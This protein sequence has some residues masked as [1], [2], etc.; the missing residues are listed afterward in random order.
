MVATAGESRRWWRQ[1][2]WIAVI[3]TAGMLGMIGLATGC[4]GDD[5]GD[6]DA[7]AT[8][9]TSADTAVTSAQTAT[10]ANGVV[11][12]Q[13]TVQ[14]QDPR[15]D[16]YPPA[17]TGPGVP[18]LVFEP[19]ILEMGNMAPGEVFNGV[20]KVR[21]P[22]GQPLRILQ[23]RASCNCTAADLAN[24]VINPGGAADLP[25][26]FDSAGKLGPTAV[27]V[28][29]SV[30]GYTELAQ[31]RVTG[32]VSLAVAAE[33]AYVVTGPRNAAGGF[34]TVLTGEVTV[35]SI[36]NMPFRVLSADMQPPVFTDGFDP[37]SDTPRSSYRLKW[38][39]SSYNTQTCMNA[40]GR[41]MPARWIVETDHPQCGVIDLQVRH[42]C[43]RQR[44]N[45]INQKWRLGDGRLLV[46]RMTPGESREVTIPIRFFPRQPKMIDIVNVV[47]NTDQFA[48][49]F[50]STE[51][52]GD[53]MKA[54]FR[55]TPKPGH[56]GVFSGEVRVDSFDDQARLLV[57]GVVHE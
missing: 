40:Q 20:I 48:I 38:D 18:P 33:P 51:G 32:S 10:N 28:R 25:I 3:A 8:E 11:P 44:Y 5:A 47:S 19:A 24:T 17:P 4:S 13:N 57:V 36:D 39:L 34:D 50:M 6:G 49:E 23:S 56:I 29:L 42:D 41:R 12:V 55:V 22:T 37:R 30:E 1:S 31:V 7:A 21:N 54:R 35:R 43:N 26:T 45:S 2:T 14:Q 46:N 16:L 15:P 53:N 52:A 9:Q 27:A